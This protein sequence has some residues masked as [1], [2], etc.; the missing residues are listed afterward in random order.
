MWGMLK[1]GDVIGVYALSQ[2][3]TTRNQVYSGQLVM[4]EKVDPTRILNIVGL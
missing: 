2:S 3:V 1:E 4:Y